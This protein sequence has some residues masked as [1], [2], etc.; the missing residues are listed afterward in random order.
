MVSIGPSIARTRSMDRAGCV[1]MHMLRLCLAVVVA[2]TL[3][4][5]AN[6][7][8][9]RMEEQLRQTPKQLSMPPQQDAPLYGVLVGAQRHYSMHSQNAQSG[10]IKSGSVTKPDVP[11]A[12]NLTKDQ[13]MPKRI[14]DLARLLQQH[15]ERAEPNI[16]DSA[17]YALS[18]GV[19]AFAA[20][21]ALI[22][23]AKY[24]LDLQYY[25]MQ[26]GLSTRLLLREIVNAADRGVRIRI[27]L[28]DREH[29][30][31][32]K[33]MIVLNAHPN[34]DVRLFNPIKRYRSSL[35]GRWAVFLS[36]LSTLRRRM[37]I[38]M[39]LADGVF[40]IT[41]GR[42]LSDRYFNAGEEDNFADMDV[43]LGGAVVSDMQRGFDLYWNAPEVVPVDVFEQHR[44]ALRQSQ[45]SKMIRATNRLSKSERVLRHPYLKALAQTEQSFLIKALERAQWGRVGFWMDPPS[46]TSEV[47]KTFDITLPSEGAV[48]PSSPVFDQL[49]RELSRAKKEILIVSPYFLPG[50]AL[51]EHLIKLH[52][53]GIRIIVLSNS[54]ESNDVPAIHG[55]YD[56][57]RL[58]LLQ[59]GVDFYELRGFPD[60]P[61]QPQWRSPIFSLKGTRTALHAKAVVVDGQAS[62]IGSMNLD[63]CSVTGNTEAGVWAEHSEF[64]Q[65][66]RSLFFSQLSGKY[67]YQLKLVGEYDLQWTHTQEPYAKQ[68]DAGGPQV[69]A[70]VAQHQQGSTPKVVVRTREPGNLWRRVQ[71]WLGSKLPEYY[72]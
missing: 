59:A 23:N 9:A 52:H 42:N 67:S 28:D 32:D 27:L 18:N 2:L 43:L 55:H 5:C 21:S 29:L 6:T 68:N 44:V 58:R 70:G 56:A 63:P 8:D 64:S 72:M 31:R 7:L 69:V 65:Q 62:F 46:K 24:S 26:N 17:V 16:Q 4:G 3:F 60:V 34:I 40:G 48:R 37:H 51:T 36:N 22:K 1:D 45:I 66:L 57:Y 50:E 47:P 39:W 10:R 11:S 71:K 13:T 54:L 14:R 61:A 12:I 30:G 49:V 33:E 25:T 20:R 35:V 38:K 15:S 53:N 41:G 19:E